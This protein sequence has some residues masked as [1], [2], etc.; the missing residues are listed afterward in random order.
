MVELPSRR[1][2]IVKRILVFVLAALW[3]L[4]ACRAKQGIEIRDPWARPAAQGENGVVYFAVRNGAR[5]ADVLT[6]VSSEVAEAV[7]MH[8]SK[9]EGEVMQM[10]P[11]PSVPL[12]PGAELTFQPGGMHIML[13]GLKKELKLGEEIE[14]TF[15]FKNFG[16]ITLQ[17]PVQEGGC[18]YPAGDP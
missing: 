1:L 18:C 14:V 7:E 16:E 8:E 15:H 2:E 4:S 17:V 3:L 10:H 5:E 13:I 6:G 11:L 12:D 9:M